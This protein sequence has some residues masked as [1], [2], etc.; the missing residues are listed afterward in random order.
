M[1]KGLAAGTANLLLALTLGT[2]LR[3]HRRAYERRLGLLPR[4]RLKPCDVHAGSQALGDGADW[5][6]FLA[7][8][9]YRRPCVV[10]RVPRCV[11]P[12]AGHRRPVDGDRPLAAPCRTALARA[13]PRPGSRT[14]SCARQPPACPRRSGERT[15]FALAPPRTDTSQASALPGPAP[16]APPRLMLDLLVLV[17]TAIRTVLAGAIASFAEGR[18]W[19]ACSVYCHSAPS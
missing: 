5:G 9:L 7:G 6:L 16:P 18:D 11:H 13:P 12:A 17:Q 15:A 10:G 3:P 19:L 14:R 8:P 1:I 2:Q 4:H